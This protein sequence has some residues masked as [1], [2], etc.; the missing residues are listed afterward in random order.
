MWIVGL[1]EGS[2]THRVF[3]A[4]NDGFDNWKVGKSNLSMYFLQQCLYLNSK[5][6]RSELCVAEAFNIKQ[7][8]DSLRSP[9]STIV[10]LSPDADLPLEAPLDKDKVST[11]V[12]QTSTA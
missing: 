1:K 6:G 10:Y 7:E 11:T 5:V 2:T 3:K 9:P 12:W 8:P 4:K